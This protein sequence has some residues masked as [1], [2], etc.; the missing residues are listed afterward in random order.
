MNR[1]KNWW[2]N[3]N[4]ILAYLFAKVVLALFLLL[5]AQTF[6][7]L[8]NTRIFHVDGWAEWRPI[9]WGNIVFGAAT[10]GIMLIPYFFANIIPFRFRWNKVYHGIV[11]VLLYCI[12]VLFILIANTCDA[13][14]YQ[15]T[16]RRLSGEI[17][18]YLGISGDMGSLWGHFVI[19]YWQ[20]TLFA[21]V[22]VALFFW[23]NSKIHLAERIKYRKFIVAN[24]LTLLI[25]AACIFFIINDNFLKEK[26][27]HDPAMFSQHKNSA[28]VTNST[29]SII[30]TL[31]GGTLH[32][33]NFMDAKQAAAL[34]NPV[35][36][37]TDEMTNWESDHIPAWAP[38]GG[39]TLIEDSLKHTSTRRMNVVV[40]VLESFS[41]EYMGCYNKNAKQSFTPFLDSLAQHS[42]VYQGRANGKK[43]IEGIP[44][45]FSSVPTL[46]PFPLNMSDYAGNDYHALPAILHENGYHTAFF[47]GSYNGSMAFDKFCD[48][49]G[50][51]EYYGM[52][53]YV[54]K[55]GNAAYDN[56]WGI[57]DEPFLQ[58]MAEE[59]GTFKE[60]FMAGVFTISSH[61]P[62]GIPEEH[63][64]EFKKGSHPLLQ[65]VNYSDFAL[66]KFFE[67]C[68]K[69][70]WYKNTLFVIVADHPGQGLTPE[71]NGYDGWYRIPMI[72]FSARD[73]E[74]RTHDSIDTQIYSVPFHSDMLA[75][76][77]DIMPTILDY[78]G[79]GSDDH[80]VCFGH[81]LFQNRLDRL[82]KNWHVVYGNGY[83]ALVTQDAD[84][85]RQH[86][87][88][89]YEGSH[90]LGSKED[91]DYLHAVI[92]TY[93]KRMKENRLK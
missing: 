64:G 37:P 85:L 29:Y 59:L 23:L 90:T 32:E 39:F 52:D 22:V 14:Y 25:G 68:S 9:I 46:M 33:Q 82:N 6:F 61:H 40:I 86:K 63:T 50:F 17:F 44:A 93:N 18:R 89:A 58:Y 34:F 43:S 8:N 7:Y 70:P 19:D 56:A 51:Q 91:V 80:P 54:E 88:S 2:I 38:N 36:G 71:Y 83:H 84:N 5:V 81:S 24:L 72:F 26:R 16:Y 60:P 53:E 4:S 62:Y 21:I 1:K 77:I 30:T 78:I 47:H 48:K 57:F 74:W 75:Q 65:C 3:T 42:I 11:E 76:Q 79:I 66:R 15:Y 31:K 55:H 35:F 92:Q 69:Q 67:T 20:A 13:A 27:W 10:V 12:P 73:N 45:I 28:M 41:Q 87:V 49:I